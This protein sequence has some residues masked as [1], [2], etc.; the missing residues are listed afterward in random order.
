MRDLV[1]KNLTSESKRRRVISSS[2]VA[3]KEGVRSVIHRHFICVI[4]EISHKEMQR[5][6]SYLHVLKEHNNKECRERFFCKIKGSVYAVNK[7]KLYLILFMHSLS[8]SLTAVPQGL[9]N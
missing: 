6:V 2:E 5:P 9:V 8:I 4:K 3:N 1:F 7:D